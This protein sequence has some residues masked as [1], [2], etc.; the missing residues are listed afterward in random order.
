FFETCESNLGTV[1]SPDGEK[2]VFASDRHSPPYEYSI[3]DMNESYDIFIMNANGSDILQITTSPYNDRN[4]YWSP[5]GKNI[6][7]TSNRNGIVNLYSA[8]LVEMTIKPLTNLLTGAS[9]PCWSPDGSKIAFTS[10]EEGG[11]DI[12]LLKRPL[13]RE[14]GIEDI[15]PTSYRSETLQYYSEDT[16]DDSNVVFRD[17]G[18]GQQIAANLIEAQPYKIKF[19]PDMF[20]AF[21]SYNT[22]MG[23]G[24]MGQISLSD[25]MGNHRINI[26]GNLY[27]YL[28]ESNVYASY[29]YLKRQTNYGFALFHFKNYYRSYNWD[30]FS[31]RAYGGSLLASRP[32]SKF[33]RLDLS[34]NL[35][36]I[37]KEY[38]KS[39]YQSSGYNRPFITYESQKLGGIRTI[40][41]ESEFISDNTLWTYTGPVNGTRYKFNIEYSPPIDQND[42]AYTTL[43]LDYRKY[44]RFNRNYNFVTRLSGG[45][46]FGNEPR[47][48][49][50]GGTDYWL[51]AR[52]SEKN[53]NQDF[54]FARFP[55]PLRGYAY[56]EE[57]G[58]KY[59]LTNFEFRFPFIRYLALGW[60][61]P[62]T[63]GNISGVLFTDIGAAW[64]KYFFDEY[65]NLTHDKSF[66]G[67]GQLDDG[68]FQLDDIKMSYG[69]GM[70][71]HL[72][73]AILRLDSAW[74]TDLNTNKPKPMFCVSMGP[75]F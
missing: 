58:S 64:D 42:I 19:S 14:I 61:I 45:A 43:E 56:Y 38:Y 25:I 11:W 63:I 68:S 10:F 73:F 22:F 6:V 67:G 69:F 72:G 1:R 47:V 29:F 12:Y 34:L 51:N 65:G 57:Y 75:D 17:I 31:D 46:S 16:E 44:F 23:F 7:F 30:I 33:T 24:G 50:L 62:L 4:P 41:I 2:I 40:N 66:H 37:E 32:F 26:A 52:I 39:S 27:Y 3:N 21:A 9:S 53:Y 59:F 20:N 18:T 54:Y 35:L 15:S 49:F 36:N 28:E 8:N 13:K 74:R 48:F 60:P 5:D 70:R 71:V 55:F